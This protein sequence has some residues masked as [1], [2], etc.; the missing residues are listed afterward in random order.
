MYSIVWY[1]RRPYVYNFQFLPRTC[2]LIKASTIIK[3]WKC[4]QWLRILIFK[5]YAYPF[6]KLSWPYVCLFVCLFHLCM[7]DVSIFA[8][9]PNVMNLLCELPC[10]GI[11]FGDPD[12]SSVGFET[13]LIESTLFP[14][15]PYHRV[16]RS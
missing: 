16:L 7:I 15:T 10:G 14:L 8:V 3:V 11:Q 9:F 2:N 13:G 1:K 4:F 12:L 5:L 6:A